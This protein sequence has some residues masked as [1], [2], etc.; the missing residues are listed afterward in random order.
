MKTPL[1]N[2]KTLAILAIGVSLLLACASDG[3]LSIE[4]V[5]YPAPSA[6]PGWEELGPVAATAS[7]WGLT[8]VP[9]VH[10]LRSL[11]DEDYPIAMRFHVEFEGE[12]AGIGVVT[13]SPANRSG[14]LGFPSE[15][16]A[17]LVFGDEVLD[18]HPFNVWVFWIR[19]DRMTPLGAA[20]VATEQGTP[21]TVD[22]YD[23]G[24][25]V[26]LTIDGEVL[27]AGL[28]P[29]HRP[30]DTSFVPHQVRGAVDM[31][32]EMLNAI[33]PAAA[34]NL[35]DISIVCPVLPRN[36]N[37]RTLIS[38]ETLIINA[39]HKAEGAR[40][41]WYETARQLERTW[42]RPVEG[43]VREA[44]SDD[45]IAGAVVTV[46]PSGRTV[47]TD[48]E[49]HF[50]DTIPPEGDVEN[51]SIT[52]RHPDYPTVHL[53]IPTMQGAGNIQ[54]QIHREGEGAI[55]VDLSE[56]RN[57]ESSIIEVVLRRADGTGLPRRHPTPPVG[58]PVRFRNLAPGEYVVEVI[59]SNPNEE[60]FVSDP[61]YV[62][63]SDD[64]VIML[65]Q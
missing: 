61:F 35:G 55:T 47:N 19:G 8:L 29:D 62:D 38:G 10:F 56:Q 18:Y 46:N 31:S 63:E 3:E 50:F 33:I 42:S 16:V 2:T 37:S 21:M 40:D 51:W 59:Y 22:L 17:F 26:M 44:D 12:A 13:R 57:G 45:P 11:S 5:E 14:P 9:G 1:S 23:D 53:P 58:G 15:G 27:V 20:R 34:L 36:A 65:E 60:P 39:P 28:T 49:G 7:P 41:Q 30:V 54:C 48:L 32:A 25:W 6:L 52:V 4:R 43:F 64:Q 24:R